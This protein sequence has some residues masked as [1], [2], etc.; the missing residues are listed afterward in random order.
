MVTAH[1]LDKVYVPGHLEKSQGEGMAE[2][3][4]KTMDRPSSTASIYSHLHRLRKEVG[5]SFLNFSS[6]REVDN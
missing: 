2:V 4:I 1:T 5:I 6:L 3:K